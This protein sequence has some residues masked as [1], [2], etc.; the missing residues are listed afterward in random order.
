MSTVDSAL[1]KVEHIVVMM[2]EN[3]SFDH[4]LGYLSLE[5]GRD[6]IDGLQAGL[7]ND[8]GGRSYPIHH[9][10]RTAF[11]PVEDPD[12]SGEATSVQIAGGEMSGFVDSFAAKLAQRK[13][14]DHDPGLVMGYYNLTTRS[15]RPHLKNPLPQSEVAPKFQVLPTAD[16]EALASKVL[17]AQV[18]LP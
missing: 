4:M 6:D 1:A 2:L 10:D 13:A 8:Y 15:L 9:L 11:E 7:A 3:R 12:H 17:R 14:S 18:G 16:N 5:G